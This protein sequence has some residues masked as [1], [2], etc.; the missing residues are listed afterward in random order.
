MSRTSTRSRASREEDES[1][2]SDTASEAEAENAQDTADRIAELDELG[3]SRWGPEVLEKIDRR[4]VG[5]LALLRGKSFAGCT[6]GAPAK[7]R[8]R[9]LLCRYPLGPDELRTVFA[10]NRHKAIL[11]R[12]RTAPG[13]EPVPRHKRRDAEAAKRAAEA[14]APEVITVVFFEDVDALMRTALPHCAALRL[15]EPPVPL[16]PC[17]S[18][19]FLNEVCLLENGGLFKLRGYVPSKAGPLAPPTTPR[20]RRRRRRPRRPHQRH[21]QPQPQPHRKPPRRRSRPWTALL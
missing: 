3:L 20:R 14:A 8:D 11:E 18:M 4:C 9:R 21:H 2:L 19:D 15:G 12:P 7:Q 10:Y 6:M 13:E 1:D 5:A 17:S 16:R